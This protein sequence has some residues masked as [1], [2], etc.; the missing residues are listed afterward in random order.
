VKWEE[1]TRTEKYTVNE[2]NVADVVGM[3]TGIPTNRI[4]QKKATSFSIWPKS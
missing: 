3:M 4:A 2:E 1:K